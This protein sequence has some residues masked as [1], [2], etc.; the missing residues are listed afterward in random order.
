M[1]AGV[2]S[3]L[4]LLI[5]RHAK[6]ASGLPVSDHDRPLTDRGERQAAA[7]GVRLADESLLPRRIITS[8][9]QRAQTTALHVAD[10]CGLEDSIIQLPSLYLADLKQLLAIVRGLP[11]A[12]DRVLLVGHNPGLEQLVGALTGVHAHLAT[13]SLVRVVPATD[14]W[15]QI[16]PDGQHLLRG[17]WH[18]AH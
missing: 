17:L 2:S 16:T 9:A 10:A 1:T 3:M 15:D 4:D 8:T 5:L 12:L 18:V 7:V 13:A 6:A 14:R 11:D